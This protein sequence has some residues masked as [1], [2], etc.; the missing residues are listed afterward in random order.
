MPTIT[1]YEAA[2]V[3]ECDFS[4]GRAT[5]AVY[6]APGVTVDG[7]LM[8]AHAVLVD[9][10]ELRLVSLVDRIPFRLTVADGT[11]VDVMIP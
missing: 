11:A 6:V 8:S 7:E 3:V 4:A 2:D 1:T 9:R 10:V 5:V